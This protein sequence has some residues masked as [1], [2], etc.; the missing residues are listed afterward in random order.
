[1]R[2]GLSFL[3]SS[4]LL[5]SFLGWLALLSLCT[6]LASL[7][8]I[9]WLVGRLPRDTF[10]KLYRDLPPSKTLSFG[11][12]LMVVIRNSLGM[13][14]V[15]AGIIMLFLPGQGLLTILLGILLVSFPGKKRILKGL[16]GL[17]KIQRSMDWIRTKLGK[18][19]FIWPES[20]DNCT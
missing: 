16:A 1:M 6:F 14:L 11:Y 7:V 8:L 3:A 13:L 19:P 5:P 4:K 20:R 2:A 10:I 12:L 15:L 18:Q 17:P 9:P